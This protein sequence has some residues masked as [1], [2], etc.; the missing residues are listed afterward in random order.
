[1]KIV[2]HIA[3]PSG[4]G[5]T[6]LLEKIHNQFPS[7]VTKDLDEF[8]DEASNMLGLDSTQKKTW[9]AE[10]FKK[11]ADLRQKLMDDFILQHK[12]QTS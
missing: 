4:S 1:M 10:D 9:Q 12:E 6:T 5:K 2:C 7:I 11:L 3:G 8:D